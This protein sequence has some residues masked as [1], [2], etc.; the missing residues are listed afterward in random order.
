M[1]VVAWSIEGRGEHSK[2]TAGLMF[3]G[4]SQDDLDR[5][6]HYVE[7]RKDR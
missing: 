4:I 1:A 3:L 5:I 2:F 6:G 7:G